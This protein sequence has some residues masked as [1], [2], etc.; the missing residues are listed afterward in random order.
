[1]LLGGKNNTVSSAAIALRAS[2]LCGRV[3]TPSL[4]QFHGIVTSPPMLQL[5]DKA[6]RQW[7][8]ILVKRKLELCSKPIIALG[9]S[10]GQFKQARRRSRRL[11]WNRCAI[12]CALKDRGRWPVQHY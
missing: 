4:T 9:L 3:K 1:M 12:F 8:K 10:F 5:G 2:K 11:D 7:K 6:A